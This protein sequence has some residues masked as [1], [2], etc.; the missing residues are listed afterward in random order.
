MVISIFFSGV[1]VGGGVD[2]I[3]QESSRKGENTT[4]EL[5]AKVKRKIR[6]RKWKI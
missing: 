3:S 5:R 2:L 1:G 4:L 6:V